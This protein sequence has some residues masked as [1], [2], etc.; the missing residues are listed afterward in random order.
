MYCMKCGAKL[1]DTEVK[2]PL[3]GFTLPRISPLQE[4]GVYPRTKRPR[5]REDFKGVL[6]FL[7]ILFL[8]L[9]GVLV[10]LERNLSGTFRLSGAALVVLFFFYTAFFLPRWFSRPNPVIFFPV[11]ALIFLICLF[12]VDLL[13]G[14]GW[15]FPLALPVLTPLILMI[16]TVVTLSRYLSRGKLYIYGGFF[17]GL[18]LLSLLFEIL[19]RAFF[20]LPILLTFSLLPFIFLFAIGMGLI[21][22]AIVPSFRR[23]FER[24]FFV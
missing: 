23:Y 20:A 24:R 8:A 22:I 21:I 9:C 18:G 10:L 11:S 16:E 19:Y 4:K 12:V 1:S 13:W 15:F 3:C 14:S 2:C 7:T 5:D 17:I 6:L